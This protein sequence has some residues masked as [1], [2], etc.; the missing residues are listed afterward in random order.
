MDTVDS[1]LD[2]VGNTPLVKLSRF[3]ADV[4]PTILELMGVP[5]PDE[6]TGKSLLQG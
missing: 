6:M 2:V 1:L 5:Q 4:A 3:S